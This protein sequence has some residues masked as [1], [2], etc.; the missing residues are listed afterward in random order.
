M[1]EHK[2]GTEL[3]THQERLDDREFSPKLP[4]EFGLNIV[5]EIFTR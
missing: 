4:N 2:L 1:T 5:N 3:W